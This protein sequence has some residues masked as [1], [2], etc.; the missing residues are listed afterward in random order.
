M[1]AKTYNTIFLAL[2]ICT[3]AWMVYKIGVDAIWQNV[4][5]TGIWFL[6]VIL[7]WFFIYLLNALAFREIIYEKDLQHTDVSLWGVFKVTVSGY[8]INYITPF[9]AL[10]GEPYRVMELRHKL[11]ANKATSSVLLYNMMHMLS[12][13]VF[14]M[15][16]VIVIIIFLRPTGAA[17]IG[18]IA[19]FVIF[20]GMLHWVFAKYKKGLLMVTFNWLAKW[21]FIKN[22]VQRFIEKR[23]SNLIEI[24]R[25]ISELFSLRRGTFYASLFFEFIARV[26]GCFEIYF[27][28]VALGSGIS[29][30]D[31]FIISAGSSLFANM[32][33]F[34]PM[35]LGA[36]EGGF[37]LA[38]QSI[39]LAG[40]ASAGIFMSLVTR[41]RELV[42]IF[43]GLML[44]K[45]KTKL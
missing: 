6:P 4:L 21:P 1:K 18:C 26:I 15:L 42:W 32:I 41:I 38:L 28:G 19:T 30:L 7:I 35:Q 17:L 37:V 39:G 45:L 33:F 40:A 3:L 25:H 22:R 8:A 11:D 43:I 13:I 2:G 12:H 24:D 20:Y 31:A 27:I 10:G 16:S 23:S 9:I 29:V 14:W 5:K 34:S 44:V 36:R